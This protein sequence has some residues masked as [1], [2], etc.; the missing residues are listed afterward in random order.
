MTA[1]RVLAVAVLVLL[2]VA[3]AARAGDRAFELSLTAGGTRLSIE[4]DDALDGQWGVTVEP[5][6]SLAPLSGTPEFR[7]GAG[8]GLAWISA[9]IDN[10]FIAGQLDLFLITPELL[11]SWRQ[12]VAEAWYVEPGVG[13]GAVIGAVDFVGVEW[14]SGYSARPFVRIGYQADTWSAGVEASYR[15]GRLDL[16]E[17][18]GDLENLTVALF[19]AAKL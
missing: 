19:I 7:I 13:V 12:P 2:S 14:G 10:E 8:V 15:F 18:D 6:F 1:H 3:A 17:S 4:D 5:S 16:G 11:L 9:D